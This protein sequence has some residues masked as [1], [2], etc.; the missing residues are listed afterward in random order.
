MTL[1]RK[2]YRIVA[3]LHVR[4]DVPGSPGGQEETLAEVER[5]LKAF[6]ARRQGWP[7]LGPTVR[8]TA[9]VHPQVTAVADSLWDLG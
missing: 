4:C 9:V 3:T 8:V 5:F 6:D 7:V 1:D 2:Y